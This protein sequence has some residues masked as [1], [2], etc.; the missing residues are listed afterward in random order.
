MTTIIQSSIMTPP[1]KKEKRTE[2]KEKPNP[3]LAFVC[4]LF[5]PHPL[6]E[7]KNKSLNFHHF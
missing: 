7:K 2:K 5:F 1:T 6:E 3:W 4:L